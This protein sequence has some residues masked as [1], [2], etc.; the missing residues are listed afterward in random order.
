MQWTCRRNSDN[1]D[2]EERKLMHMRYSLHLDQES[3]SKDI[4][5][6]WTFRYSRVCS[7]DRR[8]RL[9]DN[10]GL[11]SK[12]GKVFSKSAAHLIR[13][14]RLHKAPAIIWYEVYSLI[15]IEWRKCFHLNPWPQQR[16]QT[17]RLLCIKVYP[18]L[19]IT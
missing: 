6:C 15:S 9:S 18:L 13:D 4:I 3:Q 1:L 19:K 7:T 8:R 2:K 5:L 10:P 12:P 17:A 11:A 16:H 14:T